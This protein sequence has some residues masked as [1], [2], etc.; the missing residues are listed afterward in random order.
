MKSLRYQ[1][2]HALDNIYPR[3]YTPELLIVDVRVQGGAPTPSEL[4][5]ELRQLEGK[6]LVRSV[7]DEVDDE[8]IRWGITGDGQ[9]MLK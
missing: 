3:R 8:V 1:I 4:A 6:G 7:R 9:A 2:L 5:R